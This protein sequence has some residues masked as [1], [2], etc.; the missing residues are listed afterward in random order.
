MAS[1]P[2]CWASTSATAELRYAGRVGTGFD[3]AM[4]DDLTRRLSRLRR[5]DPPFV[6]PPR[7]RLARGVQ[8]VEPRLVAEV[9]FA[10][11][12]ADGLVRQASFVGLRE[13]KPQAEVTMEKAQVAPSA[14]ARVVRRTARPARSAR[15]DRALVSDVVI[16]HPERVVYLD[17]QTTKLAVAE[18]YAT[19][20]PRLLPHLNGRPL[21]IVRCPEGAQKACFYQK[22][23]GKADIPGVSFAM[24]DDGSGRHPYIVAGTVKALAGLAQMNVL[25]LHVWGAR[26]A[27]IERPDTM[28]LDLDPDTTLPWANV[29]AAARLVRVLLQELGLD[30]LVKTTGGHGLHIVLP[31]ERRHSWDQV[32][33]FAQRIASHLAATLPDQFTATMGKERR[34]GKIFVDYL[35]NARGATAVA[36][37][38]LRARPGAT[39]A[40]PLAWEEL[41][42]K[43][44]P[45]AFTIVTVPARIARKLDPWADYERRRQRLTATMERALG[46]HGR[47]RRGRT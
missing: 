35:R 39:V 12:T 31:L 15:E 40:T 4:L 3:D 17:P 47:P 29:V 38:S 13:D 27:T 45:A 44:P 41:S 32:K 21:S 9:S 18:Y 10:E 14:P 2:C 37:Y 42:P 1:V 26:V 22:H 25:E 5:A 36:P 43:V 6:E 46:A 34:R 24:I 16:T 33:G 20:A 19:V 11:W 23:I 8:W 28:V 7:G 30:P